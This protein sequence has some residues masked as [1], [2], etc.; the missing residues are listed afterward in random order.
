MTKEK[1]KNFNDTLAALRLADEGYEDLSDEDYYKRIGDV[2]GKVDGFQEILSRGEAES[3]RLGG[4]AKEMMEQKRYL[5]NK[6]KRL[7]EW[8]LWSMKNNNMPVLHG[9]LYTIAI[10]KNP[11]SVESLTDPT[12]E[13]FIK[14]S[15]NYPN[16]FKR[17]IS[18]NKTEIK[19]VLQEK[20]DELKDL[21]RLIQTE[22]IK[23][24]VRKG[25]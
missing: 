8:A 25:I 3:A 23:F 6:L 16:I 1:K 22:K 19:K 17:S 11:S 15:M 7:K 20:P 5:D 12:N 13:L 9:D 24:N 10:K 4:L 18:W 14:H 21:F 2:Q